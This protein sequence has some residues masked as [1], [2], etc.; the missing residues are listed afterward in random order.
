[1]I[2][3]DGVPVDPNRVRSGYFKANTK[4]QDILA[5]HAVRTYRTLIW[6][7]TKYVACH[8]LVITCKIYATE[9]NAS[10][11]PFQLSQSSSLESTD[12]FPTLRLRAFFFAFTFSTCYRPIVV[13]VGTPIGSLLQFLVMRRELLEE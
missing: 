13:G 9:V 4:C 10:S 5:G 3:A 6:A 2:F 12:T 11:I 7:Y 1:M 8:F